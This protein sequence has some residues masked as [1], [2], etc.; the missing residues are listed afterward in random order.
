MGVEATFPVAEATSTGLIIMIGQILGVIYLV[1][2]NIFIKKPNNHQLA[3]QKC[4]GE[5]SDLT[6]VATWSVSFLVWA[7]CVCLSIV[8]FVIFFWP[9][10][11]RRVYEAN[12]S[13]KTCD[14]IP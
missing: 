9:N 10:Y 1:L 5:N 6:N 3:V 2:T 4:G 11:R 14:G 12:R 8:I 13:V 7:G